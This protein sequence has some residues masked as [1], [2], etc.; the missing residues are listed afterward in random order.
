[1]NE[2][3]NCT[4]EREYLCY[5]ESL[6]SSALLDEFYACHRLKKA[7][8]SRLDHVCHA[9][10]NHYCPLLVDIAHGEITSHDHDL[11]R[12]LLRFESF[13][14]RQ[15][16]HINALHDQYEPLRSRSV[17]PPAV[18]S[19]ESFLGLYSEIMEEFGYLERI[20]S[21]FEGATNMWMYFLYN[22]RDIPEIFK[23]AEYRNKACAVK[24][25]GS[26]DF[27]Y[28]FE[29]VYKELVRIV[30][31]EMHCDI[32]AFKNRRRQV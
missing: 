23:T 14:K 21:A 11:I 17:K 3:L 8:T 5:L 9:V 18:L 22:R 28:Q 10:C 26:Y 16:Q 20:V 13:V 1:M 15:Y 19:P 2:L 12:F 4:S 24:P 25:D 27:R 31:S 7:V 6:D 32:S 30:E 29:F